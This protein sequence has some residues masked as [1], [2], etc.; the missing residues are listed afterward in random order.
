MSV[1]DVNTSLNQHRVPLVVGF[2]RYNISDGLLLFIAA[3][4]ALVT[5]SCVP[6]SIQVTI[7]MVLI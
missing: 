7:I 3:Q 1:G 6:F 2:V 4:L 5:K